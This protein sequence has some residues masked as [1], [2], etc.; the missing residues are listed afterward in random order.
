MSGFNLPPGVTTGMLPG[1]TPEDEAFENLVDRITADGDR[2]MLR[3]AEMAD[4]WALGLEA[5]DRGERGIN[6]AEGTR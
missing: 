3:V 5:W 2:R 6:Y 4:V 1:C